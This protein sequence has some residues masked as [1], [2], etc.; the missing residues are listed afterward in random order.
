MARPLKRDLVGLQFGRLKVSA[1]E[2]SGSGQALWRCKCECG[3]VSIVAGSQLNSGKTKSCGCY[4]N[5]FSRL[6]K[7]THG[8]RDTPE[9]MIWNGMKQRCSNPNQKHYE[10]YGGRGIYVCDDWRDSFAQFYA[11]MGPRPKGRLRYSIERIDNDGPYAPWN[12]RW[13]TADEQKLNKRP[14]KRRAP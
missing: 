8:L 4:R 12:C 1:R 2:G 6:T 14:R 9:Y 5:D 13:A 3:A 10:R 7:T 11:D